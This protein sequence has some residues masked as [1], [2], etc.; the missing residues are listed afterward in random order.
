MSRFVALFRASGEPP[1]VKVAHGGRTLKVSLRQRATARRKVLLVRGSTGE[2]VLTV[3]PRTRMED[4]RAFV[5]ENA[6]W[7]AERLA[8]VPDRTPFEPG[9]TVPLRGVPHLVV[10]VGDASAPVET[11]VDALG[12]PLIAVSGA[13]ETVPGQ[14]RAFLER[15]ALSDLT[16]ASERY[17]RAAG[18]VV[19]RIRIKDTTSRWGSCTSRGHLNYSWRLVMAPAAVLDYLAAHEVCHLHEMNHSDRYW[20]IVRGLCPA[21]DEAEAWLRRNGMGLHRYG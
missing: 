13:P 6:P 21:T 8:D 11:L 18:V 15:E 17:A 9:R 5:A 3:P 16:E 10:R 4:A 2:V 12:K 7:I 19:R 20:R 1:H 14:V